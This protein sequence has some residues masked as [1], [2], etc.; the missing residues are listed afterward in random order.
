MKDYFSTF[1]INTKGT[2][3]W[4]VFFD[5][6]DS[7]NSKA[8]WCCMWFTMI[9]SFDLLHTLINTILILST[10]CANP[11]CLFFWFVFLVFNNISCTIIPDWLELKFPIYTYYMQNVFRI[12][13]YSLLL[14]HA[15]LK[16]LF[17]AFY[18]SSLE[19]STANG[20]WWR[21]TTKAIRYLLNEERVFTIFSW[22]PRAIKTTCGFL[23]KYERTIKMLST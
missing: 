5:D 19:Y 14:Q 1:S 17:V 6:D 18:S 21:N 7:I 12:C 16:N 20:L 8:S 4:W 9:Y 10:I 23:D 13:N 11:I 22:F 15:F 3:N 2:S